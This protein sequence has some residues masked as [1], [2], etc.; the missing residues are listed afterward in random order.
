MLGLGAYDGIRKMPVDQIN[1]TASAR[2]VLVTQQSLTASAA[3]RS[4]NL[5]TGRKVSRVTDDAVAFAA[6]RALT[7][8]ASD[9]SAVK[10]SVGQGV[11]TINAALA[12]AEGVNSLLDQMKGVASAAIASGDSTERNALA[13]QYN[14]LRGQVDSLA[15]DAGYNGVNL[16]SASSSALTVA[17]GSQAGDSLTVSGRN[18]SATGLGV[19]AVAA[20]G[21]DFSASTLA[22]LDNAAA[23]VNS[24]QSSLGS[25]LTALGIRGEAA[26]SQAV[27]AQDGAAKLT[28]ADLNEEAA[29]LVATRTRQQLARAAQ[30]VSQ[31][32]QES[33]LT[34]F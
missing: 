15:A 31:R 22:Q 23:T 34:L 25:N 11:S 7:E 30:G 18:V 26:A 4:Q 2:D 16:L 8:R 24:V 1:L 27:I 10:D 13:T 9:L 20:D 14:Q 19:A 32:A 29:L 21:S 28:E 12:G 17:F 3:Q 6:A 5:S 33:L